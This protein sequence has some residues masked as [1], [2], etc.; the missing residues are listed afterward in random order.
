MIELS[1]GGVP[2][3]KMSG[4]GNDFV[5]VDN[6]E[7]RAPRAVMADW[8]RAVCR[9]SFGVG[10]DG[11]FFLNPAAPGSGFDYSWDFYNADGSRAEMCGNG[12]RCA[13]RLAYELGLAPARHVIGTDVGGVAAEVLPDI[14]QVKVRLTFAKD[15]RLN[16]PVDIDGQAYTVHF[17]DTG[18]PHAVLMVPDVAA[19]DVAGLGRAVRHHQA[20]APRGTNANF[21]QVLDAGRMLLRTYER[22]VEGETFACGTGAAATAVVAHALKLTGPTVALTTTGGETLT[23]SLEDGAVSLQGAATLVYTGRL[24]PAA[25]GLA[26]PFPA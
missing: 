17:V 3:Y 5:V 20:F 14:G 21:A 11:L 13:A 26:W 1:G 24:N 4:S 25:V 22:G 23:V 7:V 8:A 15:L 2:F 19:V 9:R 18:V 16:I 6:R 12:S 10:A